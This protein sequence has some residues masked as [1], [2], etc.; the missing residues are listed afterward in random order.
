MMHL[1]KRSAN[2]HQQQRRF[3]GKKKTCSSCLSSAFSRSYFELQAVCWEPWTSQAVVDTLKYGFTSSRC[4]K[5]STTKKKSVVSLK[6]KKKRD[7]KTK[8]KM[9]HMLLSS[10]VPR[11]ASNPQPYFGTI[12]GVLNPQYRMSLSRLQCS[13]FTS[14]FLCSRQC[15][16]SLKLLNL[17]LIN[18]EFKKSFI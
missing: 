4:R 8:Q 18:Q 2:H 9:M 16:I 5:I 1:C 3:K 14:S 6:K 7:E 12:S 10:V 17:A 13:V 15:F 11:C